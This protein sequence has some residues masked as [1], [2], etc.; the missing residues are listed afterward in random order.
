MSTPELATPARPAGA[1]PLRHTTAR[2]FMWTSGQALIIRFL[3]LVSFVVLA[4]LL[5]PHAYGLVA[6]ANVFVVLMQMIAT[7]GMSQALV[8]RRE[9]DRADLDTVFWIGMGMSC[10]LTAALCIGAWPLSAAFHEPELRPV[11]QAL[12][13]T[14]IT[15]GMG[16]THQAVL[17]RRLAFK[18]IAVP[19]IV[20]NVL[21][22]AVGIAFAVAGFG[23]WAL[24]VQTVLG[25]LAT[26]AG[27]V[28]TSGYRP[29]L[30]IAPGRFRS[31]FASSRHFVGAS[32]LN[33]LNQRTDDFLVGSVLGSAALGVYSVAYR[34]LTVMIDVLSSSARAVAFPVFS[35]VQDEKERL[36][37]AYSAVTRMTAVGAMPA[38]LFVFAAAPEIVHVV[39]GGKWDAAVPTMRVLCLYGPLQ[40]V[41]QFNGALLQSVGRARLAF[42]LMAAGTVLQV[43]GFAIAVS[44]GIT[45]VAA[46]F[47]IRAYLVTPPGLIVAARAVDAT[48]WD[49]LKGIVAPLV[50]SLA[51]VA[52]VLA[53]HDA[54]SG[55]TDAAPRLA[56]LL[57][58]G[59]AVYLGVLRLTGRR[60]LAEVVDVARIAVARG[61]GAAA[62]GIAG[63]DRRG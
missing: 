28:V 51:M 5:T 52:A 46:S 18:S 41:S 45:W 8:Q 1:P 24:V 53:T 39:F 21:A 30:A 13:I 37:R 60:T 35:R 27:W 59:V 17:Q 56:V 44:H 14:F 22:T 36:S 16:T 19:T 29:S 61:S 11:L 62:A 3:S 43:I 25:S 63:T 38:F 26:T 55:S 49:H 33:F 48:V 47:V 31:L 15:V 58:V 20:A 54:L 6:L 4:R 42:R 57:L 2:G 40:A 10:A 32:F 7:A 50:S 34:I 12:S 23:V 9:V